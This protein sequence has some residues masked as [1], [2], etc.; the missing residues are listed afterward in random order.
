MIFVRFGAMLEQ[1]I[2]AY[3]PGVR[4]FSIRPI[5]S[6]LIHRTWKVEVEESA[7]ILQ[8]VN[9]SVFQ[10]PMA[11]AGNL[12]KIGRYLAERSPGYLFAAPLRTAQGAVF[13]SNEGDGFYRMFPFVR[14]SKTYDIVTSPEQAYEASRQ[15]GLFTRHLRNFDVSLLEETLP[16]FHDLELR[17][18]QFERAVFEGDAGRVRE[19]AEM[20]VFLRG[21]RELVDV[22][23]ALKRDPDF[24]LRVTHHDTKISNVL[25]DDQDKGL[26]VIDLDTVMPG[27]F[28]SDVGD[29]V[30]TYV[31]PASEEEND[32]RR[33]VVRRDFYQAIGEGYLG[34]MENVLSAAEKSRFFYSGLFMVYMQALRFLADHLNKDVYYGARYEGHNYNRA[35]N[36][37]ALLRGLIGFGG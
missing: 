28:I 31:S 15:F 19:S 6:G 26:C 3:L 35:A 7:F 23:T 25:F 10:Q 11:I 20:I 5:G 4:E 24:L 32:L 36:Q 30:R 2:A 14:G 22:Y 13:S 27:Y 18:E 9:T 17:Y 34:A 29:M 33:V 1:V 21:Q 37:V 12:D 8:E 16:H